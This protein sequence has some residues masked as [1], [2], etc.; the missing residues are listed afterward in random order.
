MLWLSFTSEVQALVRT[1]F[2][3]LTTTLKV[4]IL[5][6]QLSKK[7]TIFNPVGLYIRGVP[8]VIT[9]IMIN[10]VI[11]SYYT[12]LSILLYI[13]LTHTHPFVLS[14]HLR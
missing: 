9:V 14:M 8:F 10:S 4:C 2:L 7:L 11:P 1:P 5:I 3:S 6:P 13:V 12:H